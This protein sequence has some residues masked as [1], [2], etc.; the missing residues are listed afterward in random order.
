ISH[1]RRSVRLDRSGEGAVTLD[2]SWE[3][4]HD[5]EDVRLHLMASRPPE[6]AEPGTITVPTPGRSLAIAYDPAALEVE[7][8]PVPLEPGRLQKIWGERLWRI[9]LVVRDPART[10][11]YALR[12]TPRS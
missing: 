1:W 7:V 9:A 5:P 6:T 4:D 8:E 12:M 3:L 2:E 10:G 11:R